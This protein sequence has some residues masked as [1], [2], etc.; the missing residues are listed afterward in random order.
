MERGRMNSWNCFSRLKN[1]KVILIGGSSATGKSYLARQLSN[2]YK[3]PMMEVDDIRIMLQQVLDKK[4][5]PDLFF[6]LEN[7]DF[8][9]NSQTEELVA[10]LLKVGDEIWPALKVL[11]EKHI[12]CD[13][14]IIF[15]GDGIIPDLIAKEKFEE[16]VSIFIH[17]TRENI[18]ERD[19]KRARG[20]N[21]DINLA[22]KQSSFSFAYGEEIKK[23]TENSKFIVIEASPID[24]LF[25]RTL[26][27]IK[28]L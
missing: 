23:Q 9:N 2:H 19:L 12:A 28:L 3:I 14:S 11:I 6:F 21:Y 26:E 7:P 10:K 22:T 17:D 5:H 27:S 16:T 1:W 20:K 13:E 8:I 4:S 25:D 15:E 24:T 18:L